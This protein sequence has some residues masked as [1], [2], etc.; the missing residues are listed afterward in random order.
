MRNA[1]VIKIYYVLCSKTY[2]TFVGLFWS[3]AG[4][5]LAAR[6]PFRYKI[7]LVQEFS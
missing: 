4:L 1:T 2:S 5:L 6:G 3:P 7:L